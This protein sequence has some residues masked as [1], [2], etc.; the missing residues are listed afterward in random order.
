[1][2]IRGVILA[3]LAMMVFFAAYAK[4]NEPEPV[5]VS[6]AA[7]VMVPYLNKTISEVKNEYEFVT[8]G[9]QP[10]ADGDRDGFGE[11]SESDVVAAVLKNTGRMEGVEE[12]EGTLPELVEPEGN[13]DTRQEF[14]DNADWEYENDNG[15][16][17]V[18][19]QGQPEDVGS[20]GSESGDPDN[21]VLTYLGPFTITFYCPCEICCGEWATGCTA[22]G[23]L[24]TE[25]HTV[26]TGERFPFGTRLYID[27]LGYF[28]V[29]DRGVDDNTIDVF[30][31]SHD[32]AL[33]Y[34][35]QYMDVYL[36]N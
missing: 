12:M 22:S 19:E 20:D 4:A 34:G 35:L 15:E 7:P 21:P 33:N 1:M 36:V 29:E 28:T 26:A 5:K 3:T 27:G 18:D 2:K 24:A 25:W 16:S 14:A 11:D 13:T 32:D 10:E 9:D 31:N 6:S 8:D 17:G 30:V 23:V